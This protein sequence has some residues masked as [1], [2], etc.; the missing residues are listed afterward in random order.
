MYCIMS[1]ANSDSFTSSLPIHIP[2]VS[3]FSLIAGARTSNTMWNNSDESGIF[4]M[5]TTQMILGDLHIY[6]FSFFYWDIVDIEYCVSLRCTACWFDTFIYCNM[7]ITRALANTS[8]ALHNYHLFFYCFLKQT[9]I[10][11]HG[12]QATV[13]IKLYRGGRQERREIILP[14][15]WMQWLLYLNTQF[16]F[17]HGG[18]Q[19][20]NETIG[21]FMFLTV[22]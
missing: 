15:I 8:I 3:F 16:C 4:T 7:I 19:S 12:T 9:F 22:R 6:W 11:Y 20:K 1:S 13:L 2:F 18:N 21:V 14:G 17:E 10:K 5:S